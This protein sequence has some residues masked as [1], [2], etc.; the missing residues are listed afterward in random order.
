MSTRSVIG[1][2]DETTDKVT[3]VYCHFDGY[4][5]HMVPSLKRY[6][7]KESIL[8]EI[9]S[10]GGFSS[11]DEENGPED[12]YEDRKADELSLYDYIHKEDIC[13]ADYR[14]LFIKG[15]WVCFGFNP[16]DYEDD[17]E[18]IIKLKEKMQTLLLFIPNGLGG[19]DFI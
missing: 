4:P 10:L 6:I 14:Y 12:V 5:E 7:D 9:I 2:Y 11:I 13:W 1:V 18:Y 16:A 19:Y 17:D 15:K 3:Y 8:N